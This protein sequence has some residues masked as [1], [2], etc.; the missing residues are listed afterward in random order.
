MVKRAAKTTGALNVKVGGKVY[1]L[2]RALPMTIGDWEDMGTAGIV[3]D[4]GSIQIGA[5]SMI[6]ILELLFAKIAPDVSRD[7]IR[8]IPM[9][10]MTKLGSLLQHAM[11]E[12]EI[13]RPT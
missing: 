1:D 12:D 3:K 11:G 10:S 4:D 6:V 8:A 7:D 5:K 2:N 13:D 9:T